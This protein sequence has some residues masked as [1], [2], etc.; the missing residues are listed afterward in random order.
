M[1][2]VF[3]TF[4]LL[5]EIALL[6]FLGQWIVGLLAGANKAANP[7]YRA[8]Q[9]VGLPWIR[10]ARWL[11]PRAVPD[12]HL[13]KVAMILLSSIWAVSAVGKVSICLQ[14]G[15]ARCQ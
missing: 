11:T 9:L 13:V 12:R 4:K 6:S 7:F 3:T 2:A 14:I 8:L 10:A 5:A 15:V 1:L